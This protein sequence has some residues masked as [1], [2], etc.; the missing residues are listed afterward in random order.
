M[1]QF[2][3]EFKIVDFCKNVNK[4]IISDEK[5][6]IIYIG[7]KE[8]EKIICKY[9]SLKASR[10]FINYLDL[11]KFWKD[12]KN[13]K[14]EYNSICVVCSE[15]E[16]KAL[17]DIL[18]SEKEVF[19][20]GI[21]TAR[22]IEYLLFWINKLL[23]FSEMSKENIIV[24]N[25]LDFEFK[26]I[27]CKEKISYVPREM[28]TGNEIDRLLKNGVLGLSF[29]GHGRDELIWLTDAV[30]C[31]KSTSPNF[32]CHEI[33]P[34]CE[35]N[36]KCFKENV[37]VIKASKIKAYNFF[38]NSCCSAKMSDSVFGDNCNLMYSFTE[39]YVATYIGTPFLSNGSEAMNYYYT[40]LILSGYNL[41]TVCKLINQ[42]YY[43]FDLGEY[44]TF[45]LFGDPMLKF[46]GV[47]SKISKKIKGEGFFKIEITQK[48]YLLELFIEGNFLKEYKS[49]SKEIIVK[50]D[51]KDKLYCNMIYDEKNDITLLH[52]F[53]ELGL[54]IGEY[55]VNIS[56][57]NETNLY[58]VTQLQGW[59]ELGF[60]DVNIKKYFYESLGSIKNYI[61]NEL[62]SKFRLDNINLSNY[63]KRKKIEKRRLKLFYSMVDFLLYKVDNKGYALD[64]ACLEN[65]FY[66]KNRKLIRLKC[67]YCGSGLSQSQVYN[68]L[69]QIER[70]HNY[71]TKCGNILDAPVNDKIDIHFQGENVY[72]AN[73]D[74]VEI[75]I[76]VR[77]ISNMMVQGYVGWA[78]SN[79][80][81]D[82]FFYKNN[83]KYIDLMQG[84]SIDLKGELNYK[85]NIASHNFWIIGIAVINSEIYMIKKDI[86]YEN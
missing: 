56:S 57:K 76:Y 83:L 60:F 63:N 45:L 66:V 67:P 23:V 36:G 75:K 48:V 69:F 24:I 1:Q 59:I 50:N 28:S 58:D 43:N 32:K 30:I 86:Y 79:G 62:Y 38:A 9:F 55:F 82:G 14:K 40:S 71:C 73:G 8:D 2:E 21:I 70:K 72:K 31:G 52:I 13:L 34:N 16:K 11:S 20:L 12:F 10:L 33:R 47:K 42:M 80:E 85:K 49:Y 18:V 19:N 37:T 74:E 29:V 7:Q 26:N 65:G 3:I 6:P 5:N 44:N 46:G 41:G 53:S 17:Q 84:E 35:T 77:N 22:R 39:N 4:K 15:N 25:R 54:N 61:Q 27:M 64:E 81:K 51:K 78:V 68:K